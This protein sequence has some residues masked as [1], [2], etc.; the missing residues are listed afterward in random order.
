M[1]GTIDANL[2]N[3]AERLLSDYKESAEHRTIVDLL[4]NDLNRVSREVRVERFRYIEELRTN[5][6]RLLQMSS[7]I[8]GKLPPGTEKNFGS[9][10]QELLPAGSISGAPKEATIDAI[11]EAEG[12][13]RGFYTGVF[14]YFDGVSLDS[15]VMIR[16][17]EQRA[18]GE[19]FFRSGGGVTIN[20]KCEDEYN[21]TQ[22]KVYLPF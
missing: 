18:N 3:A 2:P 19:Y 21:E 12:T 17:I 1:K 8:S 4:R 16:Y 10:L 11:R 13:D 20:S 5:K 9:I 15:A 22:Q 14:G 7:E 6:G